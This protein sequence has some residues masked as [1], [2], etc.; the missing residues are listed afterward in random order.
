MAWFNVPARIDIGIEAENLEDALLMAETI[1]EKRVK[2]CEFG[3][4]KNDRGSVT[5]Y[6]I[7]PDEVERT[8]EDEADET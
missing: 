7:L 2:R 5:G 1:L 6:E 8:D 3:Y 4:E